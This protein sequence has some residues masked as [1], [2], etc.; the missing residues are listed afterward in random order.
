MVGVVARSLREEKRAEYG[1]DAGRAVLTPG[2]DAA[3]GLMGALVPTEDSAPMGFATHERGGCLR[4]RREASIPSFAEVTEKV[5]TQFAK[6]SVQET[7]HRYGG[8]HA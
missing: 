3:H 1:F 2:T 6:P 8:S 5:G 7:I 4:Y